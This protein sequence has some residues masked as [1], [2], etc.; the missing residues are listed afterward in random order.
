[1]AEATEA[2]KRL[3]KNYWVVL[4]FFF[5][6]YLGGALACLRQW[7]APDPWARVDIFS[8]GFLVLSLAWLF[9]QARFHRAI[10]ISTETMK[11]A[12]GASYDPQMLRW[13]SLLSAAEM[14]VFFDYGHW[15]LVP[16]LQR[17]VLQGIGLALFAAGAALLLW[18]DCYLTRH[19]SSG[20]S[21]GKLIAQG[22][23]RYA[24]HPRYAAVLVSRIAL[25]LSLAS[26]LG[27]VLALAWLLLIVRR[28]R[29][30]EAHL[31]EL[32]GADYAAYAARTARL[33]PRI[34]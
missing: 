34:Y 8:G 9:S 3:K 10:L 1:M 24:R 7:H 25:A 32:F 33:L 18:V 21:A 12:S 17:P 5:L 30:E 4:F 29:L 13:V 16:A 27:W 14:A 6:V 31:R 11:E 23:Y 19:F 2:S 28:I 15:R 26:V 20:V 22:P